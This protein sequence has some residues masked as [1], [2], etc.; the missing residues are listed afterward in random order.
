MLPKAQQDPGGERGPFKV[1]LGWKS[2]ELLPGHQSVWSVHG[3]DLGTWTRRKRRLEVIWASIWL[4][5]EGAQH[6]RRVP[7]S[8]PE[9]PWATPNPACRVKTASLDHR[10]ET[11]PRCAQHRGG[12]PWRSVRGA[13]RRPGPRVPQVKPTCQSCPLSCLFHFSFPIGLYLSL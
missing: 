7:A 9:Q 5:W 13:G 6:R 4:Q 3:G 11:E 2:A 10:G 12:T 8:Y 1:E